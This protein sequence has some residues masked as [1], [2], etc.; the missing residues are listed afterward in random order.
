M[1]DMFVS[2]AV[3]IVFVLGGIV[4]TIAGLIILANEGD[5]V[6]YL[7]LG[8]LSLIGGMVFWGRK[9]LNFMPKSVSDQFKNLL[10]D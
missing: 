7:T 5:A 8:P 3:T 4:A 9:V 1:K 10:D 6:L 2:F